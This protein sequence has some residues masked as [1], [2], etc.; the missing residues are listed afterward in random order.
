MSEDISKK[1]GAKQERKR[2][3][4]FFP[5]VNLRSIPNPATDFNEVS[6]TEETPTTELPFGRD[7]QTS[8]NPT[9]LQDFNDFIQQDKQDDTLQGNSLIIEQD[10][11][12]DGLQV[13]E[14]F[15]P[16]H[17]KVTRKK[18]VNPETPKPGKVIRSVMPQSLN[19]KNRGS[20]SD[21][22]TPHGVILRKAY[23]RL[24]KGIAYEFDISLYD[25]VDTAIGE[26]LKRQG[27]L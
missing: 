17:N 14:V 1:P 15:I 8:T 25:V 2:S 10:Y 12:A 16:Q 19:I 21:E 6:I 4:L 22:W 20:G 3:K 24:M 27:K 18:R 9:R 5:E 23:I 13:K 11:Y 26:F 7:A